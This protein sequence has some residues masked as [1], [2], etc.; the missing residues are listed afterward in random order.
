MVQ[1]KNR[2]FNILIHNMFIVF[3]RKILPKRLVAATQIWDVLSLTATIWVKT[4]TVHYEHFST[5][6]SSFRPHFWFPNCCKSNCIQIRRKILL[7][8]NDNHDL[9]KNIQW[10]VYGNWNKTK[11]ETLLRFLKDLFWKSDLVSVFINSFIKE[12]GKT[13][14]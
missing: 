7:Y 4:K 9:R 8:T 14:E 11:W 6:W 10:I 12:N 3:N 13:L 2:K 1:F 5:S